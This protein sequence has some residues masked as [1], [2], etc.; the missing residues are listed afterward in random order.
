MGKSGGAPGAYG[1]PFG[2]AALR[3]GPAAL[4][5]EHILATVSRAPKGRANAYAVA[6]VLGRPGK[7]GAD[8]VRDVARRFGLVVDGAWVSLPTCEW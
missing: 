3:L 2:L 6:T 4:S 8:D 7:R 5:F 1:V